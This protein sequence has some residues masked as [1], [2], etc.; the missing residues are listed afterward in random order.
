[1][2]FML[3]PFKMKR[4]GGSVWYSRCPVQNGKKQRGGV[5]AICCPRSKQREM[6]A[7]C[8]IHT[9]LIG[10][11]KEMGAVCGIHVPLFE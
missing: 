6:G 2:G 5:N 4:Y 9:T 7:T 8:G 1:M 10:N 3:P 11:E